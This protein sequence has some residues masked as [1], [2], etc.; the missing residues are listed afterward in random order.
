MICSAVKSSWNVLNV[1]EKRRRESRTLDMLVWTL[2]FSRLR[3]THYS[4][5]LQ[6]VI[7][8]H[9]KLDL[10]LITR[11]QLLLNITCRIYLYF[12]AFSLAPS[13]CY[14]I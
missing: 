4:E 3:D 10:Q 14:S 12:L 2:F 7:S 1:V 8:V 11:S 6:V 5:L 9:F 13:R